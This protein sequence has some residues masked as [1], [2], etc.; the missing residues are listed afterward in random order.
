M[1]NASGQ[2][3]LLH[4]ISKLSTKQEQWEP[5]DWFKRM[6]DHAPVYYDAEQDVWNVFAFEHVKRVLFDHELFSN[7]K[8]RSLIPTPR[9][10]DNRSNVNLVDPPEHRKRRALLAQAFTPRSLKD[11]EPRI[12]EI[13]DELIAEMEGAPTVDIVRQLAVPLP[14]TVIADLL[15][16]PSRDREQIKAWSD[17]LFLPY[18]LE[19]YA[20]IEQQKLKA[21][22]EFAEYLYPIVLE[23]RRHPADDIITDLTKAELEGE[24]LTDE[25]VVMSAMGLLGAGNETTTTL[26][27]NMFYSMLFDQP[28][29]YQELRADP[30]LVS[31]LVEEVLRFRFAA[32]IDRRVARDTNVFGP[33]MKAGQPI[34]AWIGSA[35]RDESQFARADVF[36]IHRPGNQHHITFGAGPHF[37]LGAPLA[38]LEANLA[39]S[40][41]VRR[42][43]DIRPPEKFDVVEHLTVSIT[44]QSLK[45]LPVG[46]V[47]AGD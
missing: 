24:R 41:F 5:Y 32:T 13:V 43:A 29:I 18:N 31:K 34:V 35:N 40:S 44:G 14:V 6:R 15:G 11:W 20:D 42:F 22:K 45:S 8:T 2:M 17:I 23:K 3:I 37:C 21:T 27:S 33:E 38:R 47:L 28:G 36:D 25:E 46:L 1:M 4:E 26:L 9:Q 19:A 12:Q 16:V 39:L 10:L 30:S 7:R